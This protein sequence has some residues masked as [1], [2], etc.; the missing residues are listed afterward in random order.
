MWVLRASP[1]APSCR[2]GAGCK[3]AIRGRIPEASPVV[4]F[5]SAKTVSNKIWEAVAPDVLHTTG[6]GFGLLN[7]APRSTTVPS[8]T[9]IAKSTSEAPGTTVCNT[10]FWAGL[11]LWFLK[12]GRPRRPR[13]PLPKSWVGRGEPPVFWSVVLG[14]R[15]SRGPHTSMKS[16]RPQHQVLKTLVCGRGQP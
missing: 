8:V 12:P 10:L 9:E 6:S 15:G 14:R 1:P 2:L 11:N 4:S 13:R 3:S 5:I 16:G 7:E